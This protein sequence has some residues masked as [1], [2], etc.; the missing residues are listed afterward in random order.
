MPSRILLGLALASGLLAAEPQVFRVDTTHTVLG[1]KAQ[2][3]LFDV[4]GRFDRYKLQIKGTPA[5]PADAQIQLDIETASIDTANTSRDNHLRSGDFFD[6]AKY[7]AITFT[8][9][10]VTRE[11]DKVTVRGTLTMHGKSHDLD[12]PF[13]ASEGM[14]GAGKPT[15]SYRATVPLDRLAFGVGSDSIAAKISLKQQVELNLLLVGFFEAPKPP[16][17]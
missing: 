9:S 16:A 17:K 14:N 15:W 12:I 8:S 2:T 7:P 1:F 5:N 11:G 6:A 3:V 13:Q 10:K 4:P